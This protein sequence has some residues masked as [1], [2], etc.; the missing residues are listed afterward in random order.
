MKNTTIQ[1]K[2]KK[3]NDSNSRKNNEKRFNEK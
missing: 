1:I 2:Q 3:S